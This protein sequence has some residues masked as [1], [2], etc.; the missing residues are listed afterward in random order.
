VR[1]E[2]NAPSP[3]TQNHFPRRCFAQSRNQQEDDNEG[4]RVWN[5]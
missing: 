1:E 2:N 3:E 5:T 4:A